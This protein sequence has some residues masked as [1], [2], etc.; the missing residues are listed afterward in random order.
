M[1]GVPK[2]AHLRGKTKTVIKVSHHLFLKPP[3]YLALSILTRQSPRAPH[4]YLGSFCSNPDVPGAPGHRE[5]RGS[6]ASVC[7]LH[8]LAQNKKGRLSVR[9]ATIL[10]PLLTL[11]RGEPAGMAVVLPALPGS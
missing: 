5:N 3:F 6:A 9:D 1:Q 4:G 8:L 10:L 7:R 11:Q 2:Q